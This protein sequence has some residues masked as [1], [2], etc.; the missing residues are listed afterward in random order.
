MASVKMALA[1]VLCA[2]YQTHAAGASEGE[3]VQ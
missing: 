2:V 1:L 3:E